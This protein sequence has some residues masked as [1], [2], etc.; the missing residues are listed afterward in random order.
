LHHA[1]EWLKAMPS[2]TRPRKRKSL[3]AYLDTRFGKKIAE[4]ELEQIVTTLIAQKSIGETDGK[5]AYNF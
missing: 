4:Q 2:R 5:L 1:I 3:I